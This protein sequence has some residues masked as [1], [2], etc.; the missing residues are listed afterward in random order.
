M[1][2]TL[3][4][5]PADSSLRPVSGDFGIPVVGYLPRYIRDQLGLWRERYD[6][7][8]PVSWFGSVGRRTVAL[9]GPDAC[10]V[11]LS[12]VDKAFANGPG[13]RF[14]IGPFFDRGLMLLD[15]DEHLAHRR[16]MQQAFTNERL[17][18]Y[19]EALHP[20]I[21]DGIAA[22]EPGPGFRVHPAAKKLTL[23]L[24]TGIFMGG[25][26]GSDPVRMDR[27]NTAFVDCVRAATAYVRYG[28]PGG[29]WH[30]GLAGRRVLEGFLREYLPARRSGDGDD[31]FSVL[32]RVEADGERF[33]DTD[34][35]NHMIFLLM[36]AHDTST[37]TI[38]TMMRYLGQHPAWQDRCRDESAALRT[39]NP[40]TAELG[41]LTGLDLVM[42]ESLRLVAP[43]PAMSRE[44]VA[45]TEVLGHFVPAGTPVAVT[46]HFTHHM[47]EIWP[48]PERFDPDR[49]AEGRRE[50]RVHRFA[51]E[52][53]G[54]GV[55]KCLG[56]H[57][58][59]FE[60]KAVLHHLLLRYSW[61]VDP[62]YETPM[63]YTSLPRPRDGQPV[64]LRSLA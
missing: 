64:D 23:D 31:L 45:D 2:T 34:V 44:T 4:A 38:A 32:C 14:L 18:R 24:A 47:P 20:L 56:L 55:H 16:I 51:W 25:A 27:I 49:F 41:A 60:I 7:Y 39:T 15:F 5:V 1:P 59:G 36:A 22:W 13:W 42:K 54:G 52:P 17:A 8:G 19:T 37:I 28:V 53:F 58:S 10:G 62:G 11:A 9:L 43:V 57:F 63:D 30:R 26:E 33:T 12:N 21:A 3:A 29:R 46:P 35:V 6:R 48:E 61:R 50:D 40:S